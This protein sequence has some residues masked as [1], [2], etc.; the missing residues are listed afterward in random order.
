MALVNKAT[1]EDKHKLHGDFDEASLTKA[2][3]VLN[4][5]VQSSQAELDGK[6]IDCE[7]FKQANRGTMDQVV[8]DLARLGEQITD[9]ERLKTEASNGITRTKEDIVTV[10]SERDAAEQEYLRIKAI[11][12]ADLRVKQSDLEVFQFILE[13]TKCTEAE[14]VGYG[15]LAQTGHS[16]HARIC[17]VGGH[18]IFDTD[19][20]ELE[21]KYERMMTPRARKEIAKI[22]GEVQT[23]SSLVARGQSG[24]AS[25][26][27]ADQALIKKGSP[28]PPPPPAP[29][30]PP[31]GS[32]KCPPTPPDCG[33]L[34]DKMSLMW[35]TYKDQVDELQDQMDRKEN[36]WNTLK[37]SF[38]S[39]IEI[40]TGT[41]G[42]FSAQLAEATANLAADREE[43]G[44]KEE[45]KRTLDADYEE[46]MGKCKTRIEWILFQDI[47]AI[48]VVRN[49]VL[50]DSTVCPTAEIF[51]CAVE[52]W[53]PGT[54][55]VSC[56][57][58]CPHPDDPFQCG[59]WQT[60]TRRILTQPNSCGLSCPVLTYQKKCNQ[61]KCPVDCVMSEWSD[62]SKCTKDCEGGVQQRTR[63]VMTMAKNR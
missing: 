22:K 19:N 21:Q 30:P 11:D 58:E 50:V 7:T 24:H 60:L 6:I 3:E 20:T 14:M 45:E 33:L 59:G 52:D 57:D 38:N 47:C 43:Q 25:S 23:H 29:P 35:G 40:L 2:R 5:M 42:T 39:Q 63:D 26:S 32:M 13:F 16:H 62:Y 34:H 49:A 36:E 28:P 54:C 12:D 27:V 46:Y 44:S 41:L 53:V 8:T 56:D 61:I 15:V 4:D 9:L 55:S 37:E 31:G 17:E 1:V 51:D 18:L 48:V 10:N